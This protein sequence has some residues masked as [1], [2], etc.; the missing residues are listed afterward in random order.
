MLQLWLAGKLFKI[1]YNKY[2]MFP[3]SDSNNNTSIY[4]FSILII[5]KKNK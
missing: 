3:I 5:K 2:N 1:F 4:P